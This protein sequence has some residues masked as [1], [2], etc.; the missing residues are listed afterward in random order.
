M[1]RSPLQT[2]LLYVAVAVLTVVTL[3]PLVWLFIM[4]IAS[5]KDLT[6]VPLHWI[7]EHVSFERYYT[8]LMDFGGKQGQ[9]FLYALRNSLIVSVSATAVALLAG[10]P[11][12]YS[13]SRYPG[14]MGLLYG[15]L[16]IY[17]IPPVAF[18]LPLYLVFGAL[19]LLNN[20]VALII[21][22]C[23]ILLP[24]STWLLK[25]NFDT[26]PVE[27]EQAAEI[28]G[29][30]L[31]GVIRHVTLPLAKPAIGTA[32]L[33]ALLLAWD[34]F[35]YALIYTN[36]NQAKTLPVA[37]GDFATGRVTDYGLIST[38]GV[39]AA[40]PPVLIAI[41]LQRSLVSGLSSGG[42]KG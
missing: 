10:I 8:L 14:R 36:T 4:S 9:A 38:V 33:F 13:F 15:C 23:I 25:N 32:A 26:I 40:L 24:F 2:V 31:F 42:V 5:P 16:G 28:D 17:M 6:T 35:F 34:E 3:A 29:A 18:V 21:V 41:F 30:G 12:A 7:P 1:P 11:A 27:V 20:V 19:G 22:Y 37:I 39:L